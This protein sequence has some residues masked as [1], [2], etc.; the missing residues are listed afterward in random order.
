M[1]KGKVEGSKHIHLVDVYD[2]GTLEVEVSELQKTILQ[3]RQVKG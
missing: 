1:K 2:R 3:N